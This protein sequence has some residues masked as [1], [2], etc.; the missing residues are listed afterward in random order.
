MRDR[1]QFTFQLTKKERKTLRRKKLSG[2]RDSNEIHRK[3]VSK[4]LP[5]D[6][7]VLQSP[8]PTPCSGG[9]DL[10]FS[11]RESPNQ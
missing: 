10:R 7:G 8:V 11:E 3:S 1:V 9:G 5:Q 2:L 6:G 4:K